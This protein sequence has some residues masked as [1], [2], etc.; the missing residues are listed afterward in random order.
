MHYPS[1]KHKGILLI[2]YIFPQALPFPYPPSLTGQLHH[3]NPS[4]NVFHAFVEIDM[5]PHRPVDW[6]RR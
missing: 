6:P 5:M 4:P 3:P 1:S 2:C